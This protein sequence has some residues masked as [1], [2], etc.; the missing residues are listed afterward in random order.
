MVNWNYTRLF[1]THFNHVEIYHMT[2]L[3]M[4]EINPFQPYSAVNPAVA[5]SL[6]TL[7]LYH[8][9]RRWHGQLS[10]QTMA[11]VLCDLQD[12]S[13]FVTFMQMRH[14]FYSPYSLLINRASTSSCL[15]P[16]THTWIFYV[17]SISWSMLPSNA[18]HQIGGC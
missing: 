5:I 9:L 4:A 11:K 12:V 18:T 15:L 3:F 7:E 14:L 2:A 6:D 1:S 16:L 10:I 13:L 17:A 8:R